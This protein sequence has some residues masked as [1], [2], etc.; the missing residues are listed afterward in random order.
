MKS[1]DAP[2]IVSFSHNYFFHSI[3][4][5]LSS[6]ARLSVELEAILPPSFSCTFFSDLFHEILCTSSIEWYAFSIGEILATKIP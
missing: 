5:G 2:V 4:P 1:K 3:I 6:A